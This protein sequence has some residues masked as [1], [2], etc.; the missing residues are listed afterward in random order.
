[1][2]TCS[3]LQMPEVR[4]SGFAVGGWHDTVHSSHHGF[5]S[6][7]G[8]AEVELDRMLVHAKEVRMCRVTGC[9]RGFWQIIQTELL[10][11]HQGGRTGDLM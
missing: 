11:G 7:R 1:M 2:S 9:R 6:N 5:E 4:E 10:L 8:V 3:N